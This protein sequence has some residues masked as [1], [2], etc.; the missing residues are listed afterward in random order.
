MRGWGSCVGGTG[1]M[2]EVEH[3]RVSWV[4]SELGK[5]ILSVEELRRGQ[6]WRLWSWG[7][8]P[9]HKERSYSIGNEN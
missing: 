1:R 7:L 9:F 6:S 4:G 5:S 3:R 2:W 8:S